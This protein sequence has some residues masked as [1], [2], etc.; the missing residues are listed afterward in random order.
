MSDKSPDETPDETPVDGRDPEETPEQA[1]VTDPYSTDDAD[2]GDEVDPY[3]E[4][5]SDD[6]VIARLEQDL[7]DDDTARVAAPIRRRT[8]QAPVKKSAPTR[9]RSEA[10]AEHID[11]YKAKNPAHFVRQS[12]GELKKVVWPTWPTLVRYF[13]AVLVFVLFIIAFVA[14]LDGGFGWLLLQIL[15][16]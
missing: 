13:F 8:V 15:G 9:K 4:A 5:E 7:P 14:L 1:E 2:T 11:P 3:D 12:T 6:E 16:N 10:E